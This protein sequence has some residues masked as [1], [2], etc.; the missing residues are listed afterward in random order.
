MVVLLGSNVV[1]SNVVGSN[2]VKS[3]STDFKL[4]P[5]PSP[6]PK[7]ITTEMPITSADF[8]ILPISCDEPAFDFFVIE[9]FQGRSIKGRIK[10]T[11][12]T[13]YLNVRISKNGF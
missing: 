4:N 2:V 5:I 11:N 3:L 10:N 8:T 13:P 6:K 12:L 7:T 1:G 9:P